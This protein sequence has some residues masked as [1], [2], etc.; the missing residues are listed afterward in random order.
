MLVSLL[1]TLVLAV[2]TTDA[3]AI[4]KARPS[5]ELVIS[6]DFDSFDNF[7]NVMFADLIPMDFSIKGYH[8]PDSPATFID[9]KTIDGVVVRNHGPPKIRNL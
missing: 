8:Y 3:T 2:S 7:S 1:V 4:E 5:H 9:T 6:Q